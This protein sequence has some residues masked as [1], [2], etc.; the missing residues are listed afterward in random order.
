M[1]PPILV[2]ATRGGLPESRHRVSVA[3]FEGG[4]TVLALGDVTTPVFTR[5]VPRS[6]EP[7]R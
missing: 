6:L 2:T 7:W 1:Q 4:R 3:A 5:T